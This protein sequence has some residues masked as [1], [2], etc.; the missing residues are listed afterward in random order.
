MVNIEQI[1]P[2]SPQNYTDGVLCAKIW[3]LKSIKMI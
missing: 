1:F 2:K 3:L